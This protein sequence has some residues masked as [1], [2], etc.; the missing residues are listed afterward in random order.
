MAF[1]QVAEIIATDA[2]SSGTQ[3][4]VDLGSSI[5][6]GDLLLVGVCQADTAD[7][8]PDTV[9]GWSRF[10]DA[11]VFA[12]GRHAWY[13]R[14][15]DGGEGS[16]VAVPLTSGVQQAS[17]IFVR[18][19]DWYDDLDGVE[20]GGGDSAFSTTANPTSFAPSWGSDDNLWIAAMGADDDDGGLSGYP[21]GY[22]NN[23]LAM[24]EG[25]DSQQCRI[26]IQLVLMS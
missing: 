21:S 14:I 17:G 23:T 15:A 4:D 5:D 7:S 25:T 24:N 12:S 18:I 16:S 26:A 11:T 8:W 1:A 13:K 2:N 10:V 6:A 9:S 20:A 19:T 3:I 22:S